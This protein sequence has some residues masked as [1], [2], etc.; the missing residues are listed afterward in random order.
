M[1]FHGTCAFIPVEAKV[2][3]REIFDEIPWQAIA[4]KEL[5]TSFSFEETLAR[6]TVLKNS[7][8]RFILICFHHIIGD[9]ISGIDFLKQI[10]HYY[11]Y[12][13][14]KLQMNPESIE[15]PTPQP[16]ISFAPEIKIK[17]RTKVKTLHIEDNIIQDLRNDA[18][19]NGLSLNACLSYLILESASTAFQVSKFQFSIP[20]NLRQKSHLLNPLRFYTSWID[21]EWEPSISIPSIIKQ[22]LRDQ[23]AI[24]NMHALT[25]VINKR[26]SDKDI[27]IHDN[28]IPRIFISQTKIFNNALDHDLKLTECHLL[29]NCECYHHT[30]S[31]LTIQLSEL[32]NYRLFINVNYCDALMQETEVDLFL[33]NLKSIFQGIV[34][35]TI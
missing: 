25:E 9:G 24:N 16:K 34:C 30:H 2:K 35:Q 4:E 10:L 13:Q 11:A 3:V 33:R 12:P 19:I 8:G 5:A 7:L 22:K 28:P 26:K 18:T 20:V 32:E 29:V 31:S 21:F 23:T 27:L 6:I 1:V 15:I 14:E 17:V